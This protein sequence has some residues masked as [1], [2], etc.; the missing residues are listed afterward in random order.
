[1]DVAPITF[2]ANQR[3]HNMGHNAARPYLVSM[4]R[5]PWTFAP[6]PWDVDV[7]PSATALPGLGKRFAQ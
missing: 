3:T 5:A 1:M 7:A 6:V 4:D 2:W